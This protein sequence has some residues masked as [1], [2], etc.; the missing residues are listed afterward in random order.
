MDNDLK[1]YSIGL[2]DKIDSQ[3]KSHIVNCLICT[4]VNVIGKLNP[5]FQKKIY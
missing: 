4:F 1:K 3:K 5:K 2:V